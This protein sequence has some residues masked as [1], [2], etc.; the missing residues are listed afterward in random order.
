MTAQLTPACRSALLNFVYDTDFLVWLYR[1]AIDQ[2]H[3][4]DLSSEHTFLVDYASR[5][6]SLARSLLDHDNRR[7][8]TGTGFQPTPSMLR[9]R[10]R[11]TLAARRRAVREHAAPAAATSTTPEPPPLDSVPEPPPEPPPPIEILG[12]DL[13][14]SDG[15][16]LRPH[17]DDYVEDRPGEG[18]FWQR[19]R[20]RPR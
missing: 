5:A 3:D 9:D 17:D 19:R 2:S 18:G 7:R 4:A 10:V 6:A 13:D 15:A 8:D 11:A 16:G 12:A 20:N 14:P 1:S